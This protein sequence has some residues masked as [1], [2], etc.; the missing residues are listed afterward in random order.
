MM[1]DGE[2]RLQEFVG[3]EEKRGRFCKVKDSPS[4]DNT[5]P[6][7]TAMELVIGNATPL[8]ALPYPTRGTN[9]PQR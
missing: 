6:C 5:L 7:A 3:A 1:G 9:F 8:E 2:N 4:F